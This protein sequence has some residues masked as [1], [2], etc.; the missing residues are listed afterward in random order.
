MVLSKQTR[1]L[2]V[3]SK[4]LYT[5]NECIRGKSTSLNELQ[6]RVLQH[7]LQLEEYLLTLCIYRQHQHSTKTSPIAFGGMLGRTTLGDRSGRLQAR[8]RNADVIISVES[9]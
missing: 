3:H 9:E 2:E 6:A 5:L 8:L 7:Q 4:G 1:V